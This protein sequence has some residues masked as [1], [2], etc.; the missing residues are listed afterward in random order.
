MKRDPERNKGNQAALSA[1]GFDAVICSLAADVL[2]LSGYYPV[3]GT[4]LAIATV[5]GRVILLV[6]EDEKGLASQSDA[7]LVLT[8]QIG[9]LDRIQTALEAV[10]KPL[11]TCLGDLKL[12]NAKLGHDCGLAMQTAPYAAMNI[13]GDDLAR[14]ISELAPSAKVL[15]ARNLLSQLR[16]VKTSYEISRIRQACM[17]VSKA[18]ADARPLLTRGITEAEAAM[19]FHS[20]ICTGSPELLE[21][22]RLDGFTYCMS[23]PNA[24]HA[25]AAFQRSCGRRLRQGDLVLV[26]CNS[27]VGGYWTDVTRTYCLGAPDDTARRM[28]DAVTAAREAALASIR[29]GA[30]A[31]DVDAAARRVVADHGFEKQ[32][33]HATGHGVGFAAINH[34]ARPRIHPVSDDVLEPGMVFNIEPAFYCP[35]YGGVRQCNMVAVTEDGVELLTNFQQE[36]TDLIL[37]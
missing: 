9:S 17:L 5:D 19:P 10:R 37:N 25:Y 13:Y 11:A 35:G 27:H 28:F 31:A 4:S 20:A 32:F 26:H 22:T 33:K 14:L 3:L 36:Q 34:N 7:D 18:Y 24:Y 2:L 16:S 1:Q 23:G 6:P 8:F 30:R 12:S 21:E 15:S 29:A